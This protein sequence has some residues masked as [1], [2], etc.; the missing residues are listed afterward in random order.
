[1]RDDEDKEGAADGGP[2]GR[3]GRWRRR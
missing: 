3:K 1:L 2:K